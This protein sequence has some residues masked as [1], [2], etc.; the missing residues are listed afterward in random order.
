VNASNEQSFERTNLYIYVGASP[1]VSYDPYGLFSIG[2][3]IPSDAP[4]WAMGRAYGGL[5]AYIVGRVTGNQELSNAALDGLQCTRAENLA[6]L[7]VL[8]GR[9]AK[10]QPFPKGGPPRDPRT[11]NFVPLPE[12]VGPHTTIGTRAGRHGEYTQGA[13]F[14]GS[15]K[16]IGRTDVT[17]HGRSDHTS[18]HWHPA[19]GPNSVGNA[20]PLP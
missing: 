13:T 18:P 8:A 17:N 15:G 5:A 7:G 16:F 10:N 9:G 19:N 11:A 4:L 2:D 14:D 20:Q 1:L 6:L 12:A 3:L